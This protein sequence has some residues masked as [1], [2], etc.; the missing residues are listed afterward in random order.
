MLGSL[1]P[2]ATLATG[3]ILLSQ[4]FVILGHVFILYLLTYVS[5][6]VC[7]WLVFA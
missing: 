5:V 7:M 2:L 6:Q 3:F 4:K 1:K